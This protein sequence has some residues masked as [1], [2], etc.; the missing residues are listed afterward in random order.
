MRI[1]PND[2]F[3]K[4]DTQLIN[5]SKQPEPFVLK[6]EPGNY[7]LEIW[8]SS[9][10]IFRD[11]LVVDANTHRYTKT[12]TNRSA[13]FEIYKTERNDYTNSRLKRTGITAG[14]VVAN[15]GA[16]YLCVSNNRLN[17]L[18][19]DAARLQVQ[20]LNL[21]LPASLEANRAAYEAV[22]DKY[23][24]ERTVVYLK[25]SVGVPLVLLSSYFSYKFLKKI[26]AKKLEEPQL[27]PDKNPFVFNGLEIN[28]INSAYHLG[29]TFR[30]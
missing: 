21:A 20:H 2:A 28:T 18:E 4:I 19:E 10:E 14:L 7:P 26:R 15:L 1:Y 12:L 13:L 24:K 22:N 11:T 16:L 8:A 29:L 23:K 3:L 5:V 17:G 6:L 25:R 30:F 9:F 27:R